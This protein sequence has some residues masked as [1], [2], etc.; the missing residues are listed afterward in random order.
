MK[1]AQIKEAAAALFNEQRNPFGAF[2]L[3]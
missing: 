3:G 2:S 1:H